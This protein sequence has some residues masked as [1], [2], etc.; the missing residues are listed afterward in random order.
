MAYAL[1]YYTSFYG[2]ADNRTDNAPDSFD[3]NIYELDGILAA[4]ELEASENPVTIT[5][6]NSGDNKLLPF[7]GSVLEALM[8][9]TEQFQLEDLFTENERKWFIITRRT[10]VNDTFTVN[11]SNN[12]LSGTVEA[13]LQ[14]YVNNVLV[15]NSFTTE[16]GSFQVNRGDNVSATAYSVSAWPTP[17]SGLQLEFSGQP[18]LRTTTNATPISRNNIDIVFD[19]TIAG[20]STNT[21]PDYKAIRSAVFYTFDNYPAV[22]TK[23][24]LAVDQATADADALADTGF[25]AE[26]EAYA[27]SYPVGLPAIWK[28]FIIPDGCQEQFIFPPYVVS[29]NAVDGLGLLKGFSFVQNDGTFWLGKMTWIEVI[30]ACLNRLGIPNMDI[31]TC[32]N[33]YEITMTQG[34]A[35]D[36]LALS[37]VNAERFLQ[38]DGVNPMDC[39]QV[40]E[41]ILQEWTACIIQSEGHW[42][43]YRPNEA[44]LSGTLTFRHYV[45]GVYTGFIAKNID[46]LLGGYTEGSILAPLYHVDADQLKM[47]AKPWKN[48][49]ISYR[50]GFVQSLVTNPQFIDWDGSNFPDWT[51]SDIA[52]DLSEDP[53]G[54]A[55]IGGTSGVFPPVLN[56]FT[57]PPISGSQDDILTFTINFY[58]YR[59]D[60]AQW[61]FEL[62][63]GLG[64][65]WYLLGDGTW[66]ASP[67]IGLFIS[68]YYS[69]SSSTVQ[70]EPLPISG[71]I[72]IRL[73]EATDSRDIS[74]STDLYITYRKV[75][76]V[77]FVDPADPIGEIHVATQTQDFSFVPE[78]V[79]VY[80]GDDTTATH[81]GAIFR[82][83]QTDLTTLWNRRGIAES[84]LCEPYAERK[85][86]LRLA[87]EEGVRLYAQPFVKFEGTIFNYFNPLSR[88]SINLLTGK[89]MPDSLVYSLQ[90][91]KCKAVVTRISNTEIAMLYTLQAD[92]GEITKITIR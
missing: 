67:A 46:V 9:A 91:N 38:A 78:I 11:W 65:I 26:G 74:P 19:T 47:I 36:P 27:A 66:S 86:F 8:L 25:D 28:G 83:N 82:D 60:G 90:E 85:P 16:S 37:Y 18:T 44:A 76:L 72:T 21:D 55:K 79:N 50:Y 80:N 35:Y 20:Y 3:L 30:Y 53:L 17:Q 45:A 7:R 68:P 77:P 62:N 1:R 10:S 2:T 87:V 31:Y 88:F 89:F 5:Y 4:E 71:D 24:Y 34:D 39:Q 13:F 23:S 64:T 84:L 40:L 42:W 14:V 75:D 22:F 15:V 92:F 6:N 70:T 61:Q 33:I 81:I 63:D 51:K 32:V 29:I 12:D 41:A 49:S 69:E 43:I 56:I 57:D 58:N 52:I 73:Y 54:G 59:S 48:S